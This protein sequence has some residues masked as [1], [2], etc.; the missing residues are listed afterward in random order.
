MRRLSAHYI[1]TGTGTI[2]NKGIICIDDQG[3]VADILDTHGEPEEKAGVEFYSGII[4]PAFIN[5]RC[6]PDLTHLRGASTTKSGLEEFL[7]NVE[8]R[9]NL[10]QKSTD[11]DIIKAGSELWREGVIAVGDVSNTNNTS[12][13]ICPD[14]KL[15]IENHPPDF[16]LL[17]KNNVHICIGT[18][19][20]S[21]NN[22]LS[23]LDEL[24]TIQS[25]FP[26]VTLAEMIIW[27]TRNG[28]EVLNLDAWA[29]TIELG[30]SPGINLLTGIDL[31][32]LRLQPHSK[33]KRLF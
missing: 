26:S 19:S 8:G 28:A 14:S 32:Q 21:S 31:Q 24:K 25:Q 18:D 16:E 9:R 4:T 5:A 2:L 13:V 23:I 29:G 30:K 17:R 6:H 12:F 7:G 1:F 22:K 11:Y 33:V 27:A 3:F 15:F 20:L 10:L